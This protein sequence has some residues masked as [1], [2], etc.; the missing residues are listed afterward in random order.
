[1]R[2]KNT[3]EVKMVAERI[4]RTKKNEEEAETRR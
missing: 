4:S 3:G 2:K 1:M